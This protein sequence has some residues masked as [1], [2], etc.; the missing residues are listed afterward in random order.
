MVNFC[1]LLVD[2]SLHVLA[3]H[4][5]AASLILMTSYITYSLVRQHYVVLELMGVKNLRKIRILVQKIFKG[6]SNALFKMAE[7]V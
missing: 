6:N 1:D 3:R 7:S 4:Y 5:S 2:K